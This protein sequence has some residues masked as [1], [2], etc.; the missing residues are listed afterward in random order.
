ML[1]GFGIARQVFTHVRIFQG[2]GLRLGLVAEADVATK[3]NLQSG[4][5]PL[6]EDTVQADAK[7]TATEIAERIA[8][9]YRRQGWIK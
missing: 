2:T 5:G 6:L 7:R 8:D 3:S 4:L 1:V 9:Y